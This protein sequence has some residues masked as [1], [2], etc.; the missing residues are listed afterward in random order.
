MGKGNAR[1]FQGLQV[2]RAK[3]SITSWGLPKAGTEME[4]G[5]RDVYC[6][7]TYVP[8]RGR[9][10]DGQRKMSACPADPE[11]PQPAPCTSLP[12]TLE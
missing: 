6:G 10:Q 5:V 9:K 8:G 4:F 7:S 12:G 1:G 11:E 2:R 3:P